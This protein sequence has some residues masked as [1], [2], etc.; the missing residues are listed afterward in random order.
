MGP[1]RSNERLTG[2]RWLAIRRRIM[3]RDLYTC[4]N[5]LCAVITISGEVDHK[6]PLEQGGTDHEDNLQYLCKPCHVT[7]TNRDQGLK[8]TIGSDIDGWPTHETT[9]KELK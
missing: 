2:R 3:I 9:F 1:S 6:I 8:V 7:K 4:K 5:P